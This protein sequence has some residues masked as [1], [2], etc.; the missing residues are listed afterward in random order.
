MRVQKTFVHTGMTLTH[1]TFRVRET[2]HACASGCR[3]PSGTLVTRRAA[4]LREHLIPGCRVGYDLM[5]YVGLERFL[6]H[7]EAL[8]MARAEQLRAAFAEDGGWPLHIDA[9]GEDGRGTLLVAYAG[10]RAWAVGAWKIPTERADAVVPCLHE[11]VRRF[12]TPCAVVRDLGRAMIP[13]IGDLL[14]EL[15]L[16]IPVLACHYHF[17]RDI[18]TDLLESGYGELRELFRRFKVRPGLR[19]LARDLGRNLGAGIAEARAELKVWQD[20]DADSHV[21]PAGRTGLAVVRALAQWALDYGTDSSGE[22]F[23]FDRPYLDLYERCCRVRRAVDAFLRTPPAERKLRNAVLRLQRVLDPVLCEVPFAKATERLRA[24]AELFD[25]LRD[26]L[27][28]VPNPRD[29]HSTP[30]AAAVKPERAAAELQDIRE[31]VERLQISLHQRR[32][33]RGPAQHIRQAID[34]ILD[35]LRRHADT[36]WGHVICLPQELGGGIRLVDRTNNS[37]ESYFRRIK[38]GERR[39]SGRKILTQDLERLP[40]AAALAPNLDCPDY[41]AILC[42]N[43]ARLPHAFAQLRNADQHHS[44]LAGASVVAQANTATTPIASASLPAAD[45]SIVRSDAMSRRVNSAARSRAPR[46]PPRH[47]HTASATAE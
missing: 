30:A 5:V 24:R 40:P 28:L 31:A 29:T 39:R 32:P 25:E 22:D 20:H 19:A 41:V 37:L 21:L 45:R 14:T 16:D 33:S 17:L 11:V 12:G 9:T 47:R 36:L 13:A 44:A 6:Q 2:V 42:G 3:Y 38:H 46:T 15:D 35:H 4:S 7:L 23:P 10:W 43:L 8:H 18:G 26:A 34:L 1:G 27:R